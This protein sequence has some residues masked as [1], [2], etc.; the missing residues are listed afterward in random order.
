MCPP[1]EVSNDESSD[2]EI[3][4]NEKDSDEVNVDCD[5]WLSP[6]RCD[7]EVATESEISLWVVCELVLSN[8][9]SSS[10]TGL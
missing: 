1:L 4:D 3:E 5:C 7:G 9:D 2:V 8:I 6:S 10:V